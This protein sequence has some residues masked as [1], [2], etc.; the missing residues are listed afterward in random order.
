VKI[1]DLVRYRGGLYWLRGFTPRS[2]H[3]QQAELEDVTTGEWI[4][5]P[6]TRVKPTEADD[7]DEGSSP[8][9]TGSVA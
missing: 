1:G 3:E 6:A 2:V 9:E 5:A 8:S 7:S 4:R